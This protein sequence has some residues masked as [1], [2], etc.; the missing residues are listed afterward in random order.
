M[1]IWGNISV[2][3]DPIA[4]RRG[5]WGTESGEA[6]SVN[7]EKRKVSWL[8]TGRMRKMMR[9]KR[10]GNQFVREAEEVF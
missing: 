3:H 8:R 6:I 5:Y 4:Q 10:E 1:V 9:A 7:V 2:L